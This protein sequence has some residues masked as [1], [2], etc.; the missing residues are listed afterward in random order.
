MSS[1]QIFYGYKSRQE[2][3]QFEHAVIDKVC[4]FVAFFHHLYAAPM[5][6]ILLAVTY[7]LNTKE[8]TKYNKNELNVL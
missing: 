8:C 1:Y 2:W 3:H 5:F 7:I 6:H 4:K